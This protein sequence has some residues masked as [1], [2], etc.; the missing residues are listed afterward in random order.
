MARVLCIYHVLSFLSLG[1]KI[2]SFHLRVTFSA[3]L[4]NLYCHPFGLCS[5]GAGF[6]SSRPRPGTLIFISRKWH[7]VRLTLSLD[8]AV[9]RAEKRNGRA[10][11][12]S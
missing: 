12:G 2:G 5:L 11:I 1:V 8:T 10:C 6:G 3:V 7:C 4:D 9:T